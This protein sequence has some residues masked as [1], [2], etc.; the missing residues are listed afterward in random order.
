[1]QTDSSKANP[2]SGTVLPY[3]DEEKSSRVVFRCK[4]RLTE[5]LEA[6]RRTRLAAN[7]EG[8]IS[9]VAREGLEF[10]IRHEMG[11]MEDAKSTVTIQN[12]LTKSDRDKSRNRMKRDA[13]DV[14]HE[15]IGIRAAASGQMQ[16][17]AEEI[18]K[19]AA[20]MLRE[21]QQENQNALGRMDRRLERMESLFR[22]TSDRVTAATH[23]KIEEIRDAAGFFDSYMGWANKEFWQIRDVAD[24]LER[25]ERSLAKAELG[26]SAALDDSPQRA[27]QAA[28]REGKPC[29]IAASPTPQLALQPQ[30]QPQSR[31][32][33]PDISAEAPAPRKSAVAPAKPAAANAAGGP[34][35]QRP[36]SALDWGH[37]WEAVA[38][39][40]IGRLELPKP[41]KEALLISGSPTPKPFAIPFKKAAEG[42]SQG[43]LGIGKRHPKI[44]A[45]PIY[46]R[47]GEQ[48]EEKDLLIW[49]VRVDDELHY[50][51]DR[52]RNWDDEVIV[53]LA[54]S[55]KPLSFSWDPD[56]E[57]WKSQLPDGGLW[58][59]KIPA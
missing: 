39:P 9:D 12:Y 33:T 13:Q 37:I 41:A 42:I 45:W 31:I 38:K 23:K 36:V 53:S 59:F 43:F 47:K 57:R 22:E 14:L 11:V 21:I 56:G 30:E 19:S 58:S 26:A 4:P 17:I 2:Q 28:K 52:S 54:R 29:D 48:P 27:S 55:E 40:R 46:R 32:A 18:R 50:C 49:L 25:I 10:F 5:N 20:A 1:M 44:E 8:T 34:S 6:I 24:R 51:S 35:P 3:Q 7:W 16:R 15:A